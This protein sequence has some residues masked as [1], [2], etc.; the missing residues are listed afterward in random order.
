MIELI[1]TVSP[2][3]LLTTDVHELASELEA[4]QAIYSNCFIRREQR[5]KCHLYLHGLLQELPNKSIETMMLHNNGDDPNGIRAM[6]HFISQGAWDDE[7][8]LVRHAQEVDKD[9][10]DA[11]GVLIV[12]GSDFPKQ[13][14]ESVGVKR[15]WCGQLGKVANCQAGVFLGY[16]SEHGYTLLDRRLYMPHDWFEDEAYAQRR[17]Q[18]GVPEA[19]SFQ[20]KQELAL[21]MVRGVATGG[22]LRYRWLT[23]DEF[24]GRDSDFL[25]GVGSYAWYLAEVPTNTSVWLQRPRTEVPAWSGHGRKP[26]RVRLAKGEP[27]SQAVTLVAA[28]LP[29]EAW[30]QY[31]VKEGTKGPIVAEFAA[32][33][34]INTR[35]HLP[36]HEV[37]LICRRD[38]ISNERKFYL[39]NAPPDTLLTAF[40]RVTGLRWPIESCFEEGKQELGL[41]DYQVRSWVGW[42]HHM[43]LC[44]LAHFFLVRIQRRLQDKAPKLTLPQAILLLKAVL[45]QPQFDLEATVEIV[46]YYQRRHEAAYFSHRKRRLALLEK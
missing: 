24:F 16:A 31:T 3:Q 41:G 4:Y 6:Q 42:H 10:G 11:E 8:V 15:Q 5:E 19:L 32:L 29:R 25:D 34:V 43:T 40:V 37:W 21:A 20:T 30:Q 23:C 28:Q 18:C 22:N 2:N 1:E 7:A 38:I 39:S 46:N 14:A 13:G 33:R 9:L 45:P 17:H 35:N 26:T 36:G 44:I 27:D 12:D